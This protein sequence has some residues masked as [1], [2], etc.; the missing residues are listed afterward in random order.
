MFVKADLIENDIFE[1]D[2]N[3]LQNDGIKLIIFDLDSTIMKS[4]SGIYDS[5]TLDLFE[6]IKT[7][8]QVCVM[9]NNTNEAYIKKVQQITPFEVY[10]TAK[11]PNPDFIKQYI[12]KYKFANKEVVIIGDRPLT[13]IL[14]GN[15]I[16]INSILVDS[17]SRH[18]EPKLTRFV[19]KLERLFLSKW[20]KKLCSFFVLPVLT[21][22]FCF[23]ASFGQVNRI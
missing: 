7:M 18:E 13:D 15:R 12:D 14:V 10:G 9:S 4:K 21:P 17:I 23:N 22:D 19:R 11:K 3:K 20:F 16:G 8:F 6:K 1:I 5:R 2:Y